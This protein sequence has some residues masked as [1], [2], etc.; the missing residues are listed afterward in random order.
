MT[1]YFRLPYTT[2][3]LNEMANIYLQWY[4]GTGND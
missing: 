4:E 2:A 1:F 3:I